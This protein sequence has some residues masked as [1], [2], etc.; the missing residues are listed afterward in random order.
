MDIPKVFVNKINKSINNS[1]DTKVINNSVNLDNILDNNT[2]SFN[3]KY[4]IK[5]V[6]GNTYETSIISKSNNKILTID[7]NLINI[8]DI[9]YIKEI[10]K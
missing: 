6:N 3:H 1:R 10:K 8:K 5:L 4:L 9:T 7:N 2:Y